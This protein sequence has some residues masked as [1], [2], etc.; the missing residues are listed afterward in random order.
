MQIYSLAPPSQT[1]LPAGSQVFKHRMYG[2]VT[3][4]NLY[5][6][7]P[8]SA[9][10]P[11]SN[12]NSQPICAWPKYLWCCT[13]PILKEWIEINDMDFHGSMQ[14][15]NEIFFLIITEKWEIEG[16]WVIEEKW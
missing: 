1:V 5:S 9:K 14:R 2:D 3:Q 6:I 10:G 16:K 13:H 4:A 8:G 7:E 11:E 15:R 12:K